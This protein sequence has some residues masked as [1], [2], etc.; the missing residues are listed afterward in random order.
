MNTEAK[1]VLSLKSGKKITLVSNLFGGEEEIDTDKLLRIDIGNLAAEIVTFPVVLNQLG[2]LLAESENGV[3]E[4]KLNLEI[5]EAK[6]K[7]EIY[8]APDEEEE[9]EVDE[10]R[11][12][13]VVKKR[14]T[15]DQVNMKIK[16]NP[17]YQARKRLMYAAMKERDYCQSLF[18][19][20]KS[21][22]EKLNKL[23]LTLKEG[24]VYDALV[25]TKLKTINYV[26]MRLVN[27]K[28][29]DEA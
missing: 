18:W 24:D 25:E 11:K 20:A 5:S 22:D 8:N 16:G 12:K 28:F 15:E 1:A 7:N 19:S 9:E 27:P 29:A 10:K 4:A 3:N 13:R 21:K 2:L 26:K 14:P 6:L 17:T 23:S